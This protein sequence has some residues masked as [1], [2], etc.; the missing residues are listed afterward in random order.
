MLVKVQKKSLEEITTFNDEINIF[1][2]HGFFGRDSW[3]VE[4]WVVLSKCVSKGV[5]VIVPPL[6]LEGALSI[7]TL[8]LVHDVALAGKRGFIHFPNLRV[9]AF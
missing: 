8:D 4:A 7:G 9:I 6:S 1:V 3:H 2:A 5:E